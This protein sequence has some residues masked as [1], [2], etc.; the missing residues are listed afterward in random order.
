MSYSGGGFTGS[1]GGGSGSQGSPGDKRSTSALRPVTIR[2][3]VEAHQP[4]PE[5]E[6][7]IDNK[8]VKDVSFVACIRRVDRQATNMNFVVEDGTGHIDVRKWMEMGTDDSNQ[9]DGLETNVYVRV[10]G[11]IKT[12]AN[13][14]HIAA[15]HIHVIEDKN[16]IQFHICEVTYVHL[17]LTRGPPGGAIAH[18]APANNGAANP[19]NSG[20]NDN[21]GGGGGGGSASDM[22]RDLRG[23]QRKI[24]E[25]IAGLGDDVPSDG[26]N[27]GAIQ[28]AVGSTLDAVRKEVETLVS[29]GHLY[30]SID[31]DHVLSTA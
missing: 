19:Y 30:N 15:N 26:V 13:K 9:S 6:F 16:E 12:F 3:V 7:Q 20:A 4:H 29:D 27:V 18:R 1:Q 11:I 14:R 22:Y 10:V 24:M 17:M 21:G 2:Q 5:A 28:R 8:D 25:H 23:L 31:D